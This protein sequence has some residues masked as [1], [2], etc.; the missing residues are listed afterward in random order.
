VV[1]ENL[2]GTAAH[3]PYIPPVVFTCG[4]GRADGPLARPARLGRPL[5]VTPDFEA[6]TECS[7]YVCPGIKFTHTPYRKWIQN[8]QCLNIIYLLHE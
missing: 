2:I 8:N 5:P 7:K 3:A 6:K 1:R 4:P